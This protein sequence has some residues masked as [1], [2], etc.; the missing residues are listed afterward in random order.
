MHRSTGWTFYGR[1]GCDCCATAAS[2]LLALVQGNQLTLRV[3]DV[4]PHHRGDGHDGLPRSIPAF[5]DPGGTV[6]WM[7]SF[8]SEA[9]RMALEAWGVANIQDGVHLHAAA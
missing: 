5:V 7:G 3:V 8:D 4:P 1:E 6:V 2:F 9:T